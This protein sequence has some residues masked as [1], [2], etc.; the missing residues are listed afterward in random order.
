MQASDG[1]VDP[2]ILFSL[3]DPQKAK[4]EVQRSTLMHHEPNPHWNQKFDFAM[5]SGTSTLTL[6]VYDKKTALQAML[7]HPVKSIA[8]KVTGKLHRLFTLGCSG[9]QILINDSKQKPLNCF[10]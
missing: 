10:N 6:H 5:I 8:G 2:Y 7:S 4:P 1:D 9:R 3:Q